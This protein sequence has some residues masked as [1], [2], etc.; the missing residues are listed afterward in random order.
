ML[1][2]EEKKKIIKESADYIAKS[3]N[4]VFADF[5]GVDT[6]AI[7]KLKQE[8]KKSGANFRVTKKTLLKLALKEA[9]YDF[10]P[11]QFTAQLGVVFAP[12]ELTSVANQIYKF[13]KELAKSKKNFQILGSYDLEKKNFLTAEDFVVIAKLPSREVLLAQLLGVLSGPI[14]AFMYIVDQLSKRS[15]TTATPQG[16]VPA[17]SSQ[18]VE[19]KQN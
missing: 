18:T 4:L 3:K 10:D 16:E 19:L 1:T 13:S 14:R 17:G 8:L 15:P 6:E 2:K 5:S 9:G 12:K 11:L 7:K